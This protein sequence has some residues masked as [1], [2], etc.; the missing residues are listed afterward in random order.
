MVPAPALTAGEQ[1]SVPYLRGSKM[2]EARGVRTTLLHMG[3]PVAV[4]HKPA[5]APTVVRFETNRSLTGQGHETFT[6]ADQAQGSR[7][8]AVL[9][10]RLFESGQAAKVH[11]YGNIVTVTLSSGASQSGLDT[12]V[13]DLY[14]YWKP[15]M[16]PPTAEEL[17]AMMP[18]AAEAPAAAAASGDGAS[19]LDPRVPAHLWERS[20]LGR[21]KW[22]AKHG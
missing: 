1:R 21:E 20:R 15:G 7:P 12:I 14:Q 18:A 10:R 22:Q 8:A 2:G 9:A 16:E 11:V 17:A 5:V 19:G 13:R 3:Q 4:E 6:A